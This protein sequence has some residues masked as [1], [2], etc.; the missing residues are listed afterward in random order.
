M[1]CPAVPKGSDHQIDLSATVPHV[2]KVFLRRSIVV[3][4][5]HTIHNSTALVVEEIWGKLGFFCALLA[6]FNQHWS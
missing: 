5:Q 4:Y 3:V 6:Q 1:Q 2:N